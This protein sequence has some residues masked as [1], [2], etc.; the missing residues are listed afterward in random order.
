MQLFVFL[1]PATRDYGID[2]EKPGGGQIQ[3]TAGQSSPFTSTVKGAYFVR[4]RLICEKP[5][6]MLILRQAA[7]AP[8]L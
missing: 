2:N 1:D 6:G 3:L 4:L 8:H 5:G 7:L